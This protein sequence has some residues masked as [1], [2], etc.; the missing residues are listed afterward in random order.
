MSKA[1][2]LKQ[3]LT[4]KMDLSEL[5]TKFNSLTKPTTKAAI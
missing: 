3:L 4:K 5:E 1:T 2:E